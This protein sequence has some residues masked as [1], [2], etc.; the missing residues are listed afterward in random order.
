MSLSQLGLRP[1][2]IA[3]RH[4]VVDCYYCSDRGLQLQGEVG[5]RA[6]GKAQ[7]RANGV[8]Q[9]YTGWGEHQYYE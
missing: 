6:K 8:L 9:V 5:C 2:A 3:V 1:P 4:I 7:G